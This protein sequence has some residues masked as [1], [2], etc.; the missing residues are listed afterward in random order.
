MQPIQLRDRLAASPTLRCCV[1]VRL[2]ANP[3]VESVDWRSS[4]VDRGE[5]GSFLN[6]NQFRVICA[7]ILDCVGEVAQLDRS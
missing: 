7:T 3:G 1:V 5:F 2:G 6:L 4:H